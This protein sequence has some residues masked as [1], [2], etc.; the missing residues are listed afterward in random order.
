[1]K[2][3]VQSFMHSIGVRQPILSIYQNGYQQSPKL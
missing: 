1:M 3:K 2:T